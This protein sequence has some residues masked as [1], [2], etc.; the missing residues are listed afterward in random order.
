MKLRWQIFLILALPVVC[1]TTALT[2][3]I[4]SFARLEAVAKQESQAKRVISVCQESGA[5]LGKAVLFTASPKFFFSSDN[6]R[7]LAPVAK[8]LAERA[9]ELQDLTRSDP[10]SWQMAKHFALDSARLIERLHGIAGC[11]D[12]E[13]K[14]FYDGQ[15]LNEFE[16]MEST[17]A[18]VDNLMNE[19]DSLTSKYGKV[20]A[21]FQPEALKA[22]SHLRNVIIATIASTILLV[23][24]VAN[25]INKKTL[26]RLQTLM[27]NMNHFAN[28]RQSYEKLEGSDEL[29]ELDAAFQKMAGQRD[30]LED[31]RKSMRAMVS[32]D[33]RTPLTTVGVMIE[34]TLED[35][36]E[37]L[38]NKVRHR[39][40]RI[41][42]ETQRLKRLA[43]TLLDIEQIQDGKLQMS[44]SQVIVSDLFSVA[45]NA[46]QALADKKNIVLAAD[47]G[48]QGL[49]CDKDR[50]IQVLINFISNAVKFAPKNSKIELTATLTED[51]Q[52]RF[53][54]LD[55]G[56]GIEDDKVSALFNKFS[57]LD[58]P[59]DT[60]KLGSGLGLYI[61]KML[62]T[63][64]NGNL[65]YSRR[66]CGGSCFWFVLP[67]KQSAITTEETS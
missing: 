44:Y 65:G 55:Q 24:A 67:I 2:L 32:H 10:A 19:V 12:P 41:G 46:T 17:K 61:C 57:Q 36:E 30:R 6:G 58:Q 29:A 18:L 56:P 54:V 48:D 28:A 64:Q 8:L 23:A 11:Y 60:K 38:S 63:S 5:L 35:P 40:G 52:L 62:I 27:Q 33:L 47:A 4:S 51:S 43:D 50:T 66:P 14:K 39:L 3:V 13:E 21:E 1:Q 16:Q 22:R 7:L 25:A 26:S 53:S 31:I 45:M 9:S 20:A 34:F 37:N 49:V 59:E 15:F 42:S